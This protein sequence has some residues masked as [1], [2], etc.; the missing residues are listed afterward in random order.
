MS[1]ILVHVDYREKGLYEILKKNESE[2]TYKC[3]S[4]NL[5]VGDIVIVNAVSEQPLLV[6]ERKTL[7]DLASSNR[8]GRYREQR[9]RLLAV[10]GQG[11]TVAYLLE[12]GGGWTPELGRTWHG[13]VTESLLLSIV[14]RLQ[15]LHGIPVI[16]SRDETVSATLLQHLAKML[17][18]KPDAFS[19]E[20]G[21]VADA[22]VAAA[23]YTEAL[24]VQKSANRNLKRVGAGML[25]A[26]PGVGGK[27]SESILDACGGT[28]ADLIKKTQVEIAALSIGKR[29]VGPVVAEKIWC[30][31]HTK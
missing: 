23:A 27:M 6:I 19:P 10:K 26:I 4:V 21:V 3:D 9:A 30:A 20:S 1:N 12:V 14:M 15:L 7:A 18:D 5:D 13:K 22:T 2:A 8:D 28:L 29:T 17:R 11:I 25:C 31:L 16:S 24:S